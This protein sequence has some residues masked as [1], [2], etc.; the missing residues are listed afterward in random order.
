MSQLRSAM[1][2]GALLL[3]VVLRHTNSFTP[4]LMMVS[5]AVAAGSLLFLALPRRAIVAE[6]VNEG[7]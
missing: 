5:A 2:C 6:P 4:F 3:S 1:Q 7:A